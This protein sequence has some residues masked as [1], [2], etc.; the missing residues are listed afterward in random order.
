MTTQL[1]SELRN[2]LERGDG[3]EDLC[4]ATW[5]PATGLHRDSAILQRI[6]YP[7]KGERRVHGNASF[8][9]QYLIR[10][11]EVAR[12]R[13][14][15]LAFL[16]SHL[17]PGWQAMSNDD[18]IAEE[19]ITPVARGFTAMPL[20]G[21]TSGNDASW[22][23]RKWVMGPGRSITRHWATIVRV[24]GEG[25]GTTMVPRKVVPNPALDRTSSVWGRSNQERIARLRIG[26]VGLG[27]VG[28]MV[29][30]AISRMGSEN[31]TFIDHDS[32]EEHNL[33][34]LTNATSDDIGR[35]KVEVAANAARRFGTAS[36]L[37]LQ[38]VAESCDSPAALACLL[39][40]D[41]IF[42]CV[43]RPWPRRILN[44]IAFAALIPVI[45]A[46]IRVRKR[47][48]RFV[49]ADWHVHTVGPERRCLQCWRAFDP[50]EAGLDRDGLL[51][52]PEYVAQ[53]DPNDPLRSRSNVFPFG[54]C[55]A[56][57]AVLQACSLIVGPVTNLGDQN[58]HHGVG[59]LDVAPDLGCDPDCNY[60]AFTA[61]GDKGVPVGRF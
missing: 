33:D 10:A 23:G 54:M 60:A 9:P 36:N 12:D 48:D 4:F 19:R 41:L 29:A 39:D 52:D 31:L 22:S 6:I 42:A 8:N 37:S 47:G 40:C 43:D 26:V 14:E 38:T 61:L 56:S 34:R 16:H 25:L 18:V 32:V 30:E 28:S 49:G 55:A 13:N 45:D 51:D 57:L 44:Q 15:G 1:D 17:G 35:L 3:Q 11:A 53:L 20:I 5:A 21:L 59:T 2:H 7:I 58:Y 27:T 24:V 50:A 46:G